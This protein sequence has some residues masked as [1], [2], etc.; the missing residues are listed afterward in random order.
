MSDQIDYAGRPPLW[1]EMIEACADHPQ[2]IV[3]LKPAAVAAE[4]R[5]L[6][7]YIRMHVPGY[8]WHPWQVRQIADLLT[9]EADR[10]EVGHD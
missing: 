6:R 10:A 1:Q 3:D 5:A 7:D 4:I 8:G 2:G 9:A